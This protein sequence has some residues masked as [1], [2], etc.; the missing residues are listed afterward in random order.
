MDRFRKIVPL[1]RSNDPIISSLNVCSINLTDDMVDQLIDALHQNKYI[2]KIIFSKN[3]ISEK[4]AAKIFNL[5]TLNPKL[6]YFS[7]SDNN[8]SDTAI[9]HLSR[10]L[11]ELPRSR[12][13]ISIV[14]RDN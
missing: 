3:N 5:I 14:L 9:E 11:I 6:N 2:T 7:M 1:I 10:I 8:I 12:D 4:S 13:A